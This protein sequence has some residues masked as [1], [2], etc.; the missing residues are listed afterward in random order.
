MWA[1]ITAS[2]QNAYSAKLSRK[3]KILYEIWAVSVGFIITVNISN[4]SKCSLVVVSFIKF[5][6][7]NPFYWINQKCFF[8]SVSVYK[9]T[10]YRVRRS[11]F[12]CQFWSICLNK[13]HC[14]KLK[15]ISL[16]VAKIRKLQFFFWLVIKLT[17]FFNDKSVQIILNCCLQHISFDLT[18][19]FLLYLPV[20]MPN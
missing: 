19:H 7:I 9:T 16:G 15:L 4:H 14:N 3:K 6:N 5:E 8:F 10:A 18:R 20:N 2:I 1:S 11:N 13:C 12:V 17:N